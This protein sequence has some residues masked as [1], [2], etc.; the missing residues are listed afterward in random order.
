[1]ESPRRGDVQKSSANSGFRTA[2]S[3]GLH[4]QGEK[5]T[6]YLTMVKP[7]LF[8]GTPAWHPNGTNI[9]KIDRVQQRALK[10]IHGSNAPIKK[11][12]KIKPVEMQLRY[13]DLLF[14][15]KCETGDIDLM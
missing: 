10:F 9:K 5:D 6:A 15:K 2:Q 8:Y 13:T 4:A 7:I 12:K 1:M 3:E 14:F 11:Q